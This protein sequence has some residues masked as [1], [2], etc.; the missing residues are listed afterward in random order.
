MLMGRKKTARSFHIAAFGFVVLALIP[1]AIL[2]LLW[3]FVLVLIRVTPAA[4]PV[5]VGG[6]FP[7]TVSFWPK[8][9]HRFVLMLRSSDASIV[10]V[11]QEIS[12][13]AGCSALT[14]MAAAH[15]LGE[16]E[17]TVTVCPV[18]RFG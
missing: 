10:E 17:I 3:R 4:A 14:V 16:A 5:A 6:V 8:P 12:G 7:L 18:S 1:R 9:H 11:P 15:K 2:W 13:P